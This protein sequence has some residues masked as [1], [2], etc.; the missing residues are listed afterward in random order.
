MAEGA[1]RRIVEDAGLAGRVI[2]DSA[3]T[4]DAHA[5]QAP[6]TRAQ[7]TAARRGYDLSRL[8]ARGFVPDDCVRF[9]Y[10]LAMDRGNYNRIRAVCSGG[11][12]ARSG[13]SSELDKI[14]MFMDF[15]PTRDEREVPD[16]YV[17]PDENFEYVM[18]L[19]EAGAKGLL[20]EVKG[21]LASH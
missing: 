11:H 9:D 4:L 3:G 6:D 14:H 18:D 1:F 21:R 17:G 20:E 16:P 19:I 5:G 8:R 10:L 7:R 2:I 13:G 12:G 15:A